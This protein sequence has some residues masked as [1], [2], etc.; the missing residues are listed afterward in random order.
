[1]KHARVLVPVIVLVVLAA[2]GTVWLVRVA[3]GEGPAGS[4]VL[5]FEATDGPVAAGSA[6]PGPVPATV[7]PTSAP[8]ATASSASTLSPAPGAPAGKPGKPGARPAGRTSTAGPAT[9]SPAADGAPPVPVRAIRVG[10]VTLDDTSPRTMC[11]LVRNLASPVTVRITAVSASNPDVVVDPGRCSGVPAQG[12]DWTPAFAC[13]AGV[14]LKPNGDGCWTGIEPR[15]L[16]TGT[17]DPETLRSSISLALRAR[18]TST[19]GLPCQDS[20]SPAPTTAR[21]VDVTW[22]QTY[23]FELCIRNPPGDNPFC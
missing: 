17:G 10:G 18:C 12:P 4:P 23:E 16:S 14:D 7:P 15:T 11:Y 9:T 20:G 13:R 8:V 2:A 6:Q 22:T 5:R 1:M 3:R 19:A 21:P